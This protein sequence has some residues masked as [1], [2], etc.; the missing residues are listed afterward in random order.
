MNG[1]GWGCGVSRGGQRHP[2]NT[3]GTVYIGHCRCGHGPHAY[4]QTAVGGI[5]HVREIVSE[6]FDD[7]QNELSA[8]KARREALDKRIFKSEITMIKEKQS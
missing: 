3:S 1:N 6:Q 7:T 5:K 2:D 8:L 4:Y